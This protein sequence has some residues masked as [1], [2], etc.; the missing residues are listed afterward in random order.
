[1]TTG[2]DLRQR[3]L[4]LL[5]RVAPFA[6]CDG[7]LAFRVEASLA[8]TTATL[9]GLVAEGVLVRSRRVCYGCGRA[10]ELATLREGPPARAP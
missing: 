2:A 7:C 6:Y 4:E 1:M 9:A 3:L 5:G 8:E 10:L